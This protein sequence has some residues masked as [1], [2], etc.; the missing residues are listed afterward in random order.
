MTINIR[1]NNSEKDFGKNYF[2][3]NYK[4]LSANIYFHQAEDTMLDLFL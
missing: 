2:F 1:L 3:I 4:N